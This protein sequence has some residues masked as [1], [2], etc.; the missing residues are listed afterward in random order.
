[1]IFEPVLSA[2]MPDVYPI[3]FPHVGI[4]WK[5]IDVRIADHRTGRVIFE[6]RDVEVPEQWSDDAAA[7]LA[8]KYFRRAGVPNLTR[9]APCP[10]IVTSEGIKDTPD[11]LRPREPEQGAGL[12]GETSARQAFHRLAGAWAY[13]GWRCGYFTSERDAAIFYAEVYLALARQILSPNSPQWFNTGL[14]WAYGI[15]GDDEGQWYVPTPIPGSHVG[16]N[17]APIRAH[18]TYE[19]PQPHA[20]FLVGTEDNLVGRHGIMDTWRLEARIFKFG[21]GSGVNVSPWRERG[22]RLSGGGVASGV[23]SW[24]S[25]G[26]KGAG[27]IASGGTTRRAAKM[28]MLDDD[29]P[30]LLELINWKAREEHKAAS[31]YVG[32]EI[33]RLFAEGKLP[34]ELNHL[35]PRQTRERLALGFAAEVYGIGYEQEANRTIDGQNSNNSIRVSDKFMAAAEKGQEWPLLSRVGEGRVVRTERADHV[36]DE[37]ARAI[38]ASADPGMIFDDTVNSWNTCSADGRIR[39]TNPCAEF[40][41]LDWSACNLASVRLTAFLR[42]DGSIDEELFSH[43]CRLATVIL[44]VSVSMASF[45][46]PEFAVGAYNYRTLGLGYSDLGGLLMRMGIPYDSDRGRAL[47]GVLTALMSGVAYKTSAE[48]AEEL[49]PYPRWEAN[50]GDHRR[51]MRNHRRALLCPGEDEWEGL[52][53][54]PQCVSRKHLPA[55]FEYLLDA[56]I[57]VWNTVCDSVESFRNAQVSLIAPTGTISFAMDC[58]TTGMEPE[59]DLVRIKN[60]AGGGTLRIASRAVAPALLKLGYSQSKIDGFMHTLSDEP[61]KISQW[62]NFMGGQAREVLACSHDLRP[63][64]H[65]LMLA[66]IQPFLSGAAS[67]TINLP[68]DA[69][70]ESIKVVLRQCHNLGIKAVALYREGSKL[71][72]PLERGTAEEKA[73]PVAHGEVVRRLVPRRLEPAA[74]SE[75]LGRGEREF[76]P[77]RR[78]GDTQKARIGDQGNEQTIFW[79][80]GEFPDGRLGEVFIEMAKQGSTMRG[81]ANC[82]AIAIS[83]GLQHGV[84]L[85]RYVKQFMGVRFEPAGYVEGHD[86]IAFAPSFLD[87]IFRDLAIHYLGWDHLRKNLPSEVIGDPDRIVALDRTAMA[88]AQGAQ[89]TGDFCPRCGAGTVL[90]GRCHH[91]QNCDWNEGCAG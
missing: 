71:A 68:P 77:W 42:E 59:F 49:G 55:G 79:R 12:G 80:T 27:S 84:P 16:P 73:T 22:A 23:M 87:L 13:H 72:Q 91:C 30:E 62:L 5:K 38:W 70:P 15:K 7:I 9:P 20:C 43:A 6:Q 39:T 47:A 76:L 44:D 28:I 2:G 8:Q 4:A 83:I 41:H 60:L 78:R 14:H 21:S 25:I 36:M 86:E 61:K 24:L 32:S 85:E 89:P 29:H 66:V 37:I 26:D 64:A 46:S 88:L 81:V 82:L 19:R 45:P 18:N 1:M 34:S 17:Q 10:A 53:I 3:A 57:D 52:N 31:L 74:Q 54:A 48:M 35:V 75:A 63:E 33:I 69:T 67:K 50:E 11:W 65:V 90:T 58:D 51:V 40:H 56:A